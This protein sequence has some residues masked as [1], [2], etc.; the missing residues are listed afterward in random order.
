[1]GSLLY[2]NDSRL[3]GNITSYTSVGGLYYL[4]SNIGIGCNIT[5]YDK[6]PADVLN[7][8]T[9]FVKFSPLNKVKPSS[10]ASGY[11]S[12]TDVLTNINT[13]Y[14]KSATG[15]NK[16]YLKLVDL[17]NMDNAIGKFLR[18]VTGFFVYKNPNI[19]QYLIE[20]AYDE[21]YAQMIKYL[22][23]EKLITLQAG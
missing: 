13:S 21:T 2:K 6:I 9:V 22:I 8:E 3:D 15:I 14:F 5:Y 17:F 20:F 10:T 4:G 19:D 23:Q 12:L 11:I 16:D 7:K 18:N 1:M